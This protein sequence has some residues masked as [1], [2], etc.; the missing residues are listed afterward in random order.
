MYDV[1]TTEKGE[2]FI[3]D[4]HL[5]IILHLLEQAEFLYKVGGLIAAIHPALIV[6]FDSLITFVLQDRKIDH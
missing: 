6:K 5:N 3:T 2:H 1:A 4:H